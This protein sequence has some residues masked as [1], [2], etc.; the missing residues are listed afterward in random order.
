VVTHDGRAW[1]NPEWVDPGM[2]AESEERLRA[3]DVRHLL[4]GHGH[5]I[6]GDVWGRARSAGE[7]PPGNGLLTRCARRFGHW[8]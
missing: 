4:P 7:C 3:L 1:L 8:D 5:P 6:E 2:H